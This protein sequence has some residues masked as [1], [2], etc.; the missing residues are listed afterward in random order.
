[1]TGGVIGKSG[2]LQLARP[3][4]PCLPH[5]DQRRLQTRVGSVGSGKHFQFKCNVGAFALRC[6]FLFSS[7]VGIN[8]FTLGRKGPHVLSCLFRCSVM[9]CG[10]GAAW[11]H[12]CSAILTR[13]KV[14]K[15]G[16][17][18]CYWSTGRHFNSPSNFMSVTTAD[19][20]SLNRSDPKVSTNRAIERLASDLLIA[21]LPNYI[22]PE[23]GR[24]QPVGFE[25]SWRH[26]SLDLKIS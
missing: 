14:F 20:D 21:Y 3:P 23:L 7:C 19:K 9:N 2:E 17:A 6:F 1:M 10:S 4:F 16:S 25:V 18:G 15:E 12:A 13:G 5:I 22:G 8:S 24:K 26:K 11:N